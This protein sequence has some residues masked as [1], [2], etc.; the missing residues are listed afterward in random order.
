MGRCM[1]WTSRD[2]L[3]VSEPFEE[4]LSKRR[5]DL[6]AI[7]QC[8]EVI[9]LKVSDW[10]FT[11]VNAKVSDQLEHRKVTVNRHQ[12]AGTPQENRGVFKLKDDGVHPTHSLHPRYRLQ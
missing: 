11:V 9:K 1:K 3:G 7:G 4:K 5:F 2:I 8:L 10:D 12:R 6:S